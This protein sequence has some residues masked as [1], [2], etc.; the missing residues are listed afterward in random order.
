MVSG[1][2]QRLGDVSGWV[3]IAEAT[4]TEE[5]TVELVPETEKEAE[6]G[7]QSVQA[8]EN[9]SEVGKAGTEAKIS[10]MRRQS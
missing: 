9:T 7:S 5:S 2:T 8:G 4:N 6:D 10:V 1:D 3:N